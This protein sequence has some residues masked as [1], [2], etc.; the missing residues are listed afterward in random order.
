MEWTRAALEARVAKLA[1]EHEGEEL[2]AAVAAFAEQLDEGERELFGRVL[3][4]QA[5]RR[6]GVT[7]DYP[8]WSV[9][10]PRGR[11]RRRGA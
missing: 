9:I 5:P 7:A 8:K 3:L 1:D 6:R 2:V 10:L 4:E 11:R